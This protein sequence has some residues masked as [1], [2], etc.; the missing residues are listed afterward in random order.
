MKVN[1]HFIGKY[2]RV[3]PLFFLFYLTLLAN[4]NAQAPA[5]CDEPASYQYIS[6]RNGAWTTGSTWAGGVSPGDPETLSGKSILITHNVTYSKM[7]LQGSAKLVIKDGGELIG[8]QIEIENSGNQLIVKNA[9]LN[10]TASSSNLQVKNSGSSICG[11]N[12]CIWIGENFQ[13]EG[14]VYLS[15]AG[16]RVGVN[17]SG[18]FENNGGTISGDNLRVWLPNGNLQRNSGSWPGAMISRYM[19]SGNV[20]GLSGLT[21][22]EETS[23]SAIQ[24]YTSETCAPRYSITGTVF[25]DNN[26]GT[27]NGNAM[28]GITV[29]LSNGATTTTNAAGVYSFANLPAGNYTVSVSLPAGSPAFQHVSSTDAT[30]TNGNTAVVIGSANIIGVNFGINQPPTPTPTDLAPQANPGGTNS[31]SVPAANFG[32]TDPNSG[33]VVFMTITSFSNATSLII[34]GTSYSSATAIQAAYP[35][36]IPTNLVNGQPTPPIRIDPVDGAVTSQISYTLTD[37]A[38]L[39]S[40]QGTVRVPFIVVNYSITGTVFNDNDAATPNG[41]PI[42]GT[43]VTL[44]NGAT[45]TTNA[46]GVYTFPNLPAGNY[47]VS[48][49]LPAGSPAFQ[50]VS[51]TDASPT[52]GNTAVVIGSADV[53]GV[54]FGINQPPTPT[55]T[56]L[57]P[58]AN[59]GGTNSVSVPA[60][61]FGGTDPNSGQVVFMT[62]TSFNNATSLIIDGTSYSSAAEIQTAYPGGIPTNTVNGQPN[63]AFRIDPVDGAVTSQ[64]SYT[65]TDNAGLNSAQGTVR[66]PFI[67]VNISGNVWNDANGDATINNGEPNTV[68]DV[69]DE[70]LTIYLSNSTGEIVAK[71]D[72]LLNGTFSVASPGTGL[73]SVTLSNDPSLTVGSV[74]SARVANTLAPI[75]TIL[76]NDPLSTTVW[77]NTGINFPGTGASAKDQAFGTITVENTDITEVNFGI[78]RL[79]DSHNVTVPTSAQPSQDAVVKLDGSTNNWP[80]LNGTDGEDG[81][82]IGNSGSIANP[83]GVHITALPNKGTLLYN[84]VEVTA[85]DVTNKTLFADPSLF[86]FKFTGS[87]YAH[88][89]FYYSYVDAA[90]KADITPARYQALFSALPVKLISF[91]AKNELNA[92]KLSWTTTEEIN[93][94]SFEVQHSEDGKTWNILNTIATNG[95]GQMTTTYSHIHHAPS[96]GDNLY[97][98]RMV[99]QDETFAFSRIVSIRIDQGA[100][101]VYVYPNPATETISLGNITFTSIGSVE[102]LNIGGR[103]VHKTTG[104]PAEGINIQNLENGVYY[105]KVLQINGTSS[106]HKIVVAK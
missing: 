67:V 103:V 39:T 91:T 51:S 80:L 104:I 45:T 8:G 83:L 79:P 98:L 65:L 35:G 15:N 48:A 32:G 18:N 75:P 10:M 93:S 97:R 68:T 23:V 73:F 29:T 1:L 76:P 77:V 28:S 53:T 21:V 19:V 62:I 58:Q 43:T 14:S 16:I 6:V 47:T 81:N 106:L 20:Q 74:H 59:P 92:V 85:T 96:K 52:N 27:P 22:A 44:S 9:K 64:I 17:S 25:N 11:I 70:T 5:I 49:S 4:S 50:H 100:K 36:G 84:D 41:N 87:D 60:S 78:E 102:I 33:Q 66:V 40:T 3:I 82:Y 89:E 30:P 46:A 95:N 24:N 31:V 12:A 99:D 57:A 42:S 101:P 56:D 37:N 26:A 54:N 72:V 94:K 2:S 88:I 105:V 69:A 90:G 38:G 13:N 71:T 63:P 34:N 86:A 55:P 61:N 7:K